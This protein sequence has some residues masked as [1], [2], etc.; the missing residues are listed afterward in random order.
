MHH[1]CFVHTCTSDGRVDGNLDQVKGKLRPQDGCGRK[2]V[3]HRCGRKGVIHRCGRKGVIHR[4]ETEAEKR[5]G[6]VEVADMDGAIGAWSR[7]PQLATDYLLLVP[8]DLWCQRTA[9]AFEPRYHLPEGAQQSPPPPPHEHT[10][11]LMRVGQHCPLWSFFRLATWSTPDAP[12]LPARVSCTDQPSTLNSDRNTAWARCASSPPL[13]LCSGLK[14]P[15]S[16]S[17]KVSCASYCYAPTHAR[18]HACTHARAHARTH[19]PTHARTHAHTHARTHA[20][21]HTFG[22]PHRSQA[23]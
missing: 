17:S 22:R 18:T 14:F 9:V 10:P 12:G 5:Y 1:W 13:V 16:S 20:R 11:M 15:F 4:C 2:G 6:G 19:A 23:L 7:T 21:T 8:E 3:I